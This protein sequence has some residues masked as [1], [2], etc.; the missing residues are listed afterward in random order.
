MDNVDR[1]KDRLPVRNHI[2]AIDRR[3][4]LKTG[5]LSAGAA[6]GAGALPGISALGADAAWSNEAI[7]VLAEIEFPS[8][9]LSPQQKDNIIRG[10]TDI[11]ARAARLPPS[12]RSQICVLVT[13]DRDAGTA[14]AG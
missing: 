6:I 9:I 12:A 2:A 4:V 5:V 11:V 1:S 8:G 13:E 7:P 3:V 14:L 10:V